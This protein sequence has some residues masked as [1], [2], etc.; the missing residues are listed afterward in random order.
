MYVPL[1]QLS[2]TSADEKKHNPNCG[3]AI[4]TLT[5]DSLHLVFDTIAIP[6]SALLCASALSSSP[7]GLYVCLLPVEFPRDDVRSVF[8]LGYTIGGEPFEIEGEVWDAV[9]ED[10]ELAKRFFALT[11]ELLEEGKVRP[12]PADVRV[13]M[14]GI[15]GGMQEMKDGKHSGVKLV[16]RVGTAE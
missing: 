12:H 6:T 10:F 11:E 8:F 1:H 3:S 4:R 2:H 9:P 13:G 14:E 5:K 16:Y 15:L 7:N